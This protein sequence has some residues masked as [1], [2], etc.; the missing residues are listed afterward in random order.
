MSRIAYVGIA[1]VAGLLAMT[2]ALELAAGASSDGPLGDGSGAVRSRVA[3]ELPAANVPAPGS[4]HT[5]DWIAA[6]L[7]RPVLDASRRP[8]KEAG[9]VVSASGEVMTPPPR[10]SGVMIGPFGRS[11]I[12]APPGAR[13]QIVHEGGKIGA[14]KI[15]KIEPGLV[16]IVGPSGPAV[17]RPSFDTAAGNP[18]QIVAPGINFAPG[19]QP[20]G[21]V[22]GGPD[23]GQDAVPHFRPPG[24]QL[25]NPT[26][27]Q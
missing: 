17:L 26:V 25:I 20:G 4:D 24:G 7:R 21:G 2:V 19:Q 11:A 23:A 9:Q 12:F 13:S 10:L 15:E 16:R 18:T 27:T 3:A 22:D 6:I 5:N 14:Y 1:A 8:P